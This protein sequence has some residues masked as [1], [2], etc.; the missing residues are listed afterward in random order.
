MMAGFFGGHAEPMKKFCESI[1]YFYVN[2]MIQKNRIDNEQSSMII[3]CQKNMKGFVFIAPDNQFD[4][5]NF[6]VFASGSQIPV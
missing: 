6:L 2:E 1:L 5:Y 3:E 4:Y